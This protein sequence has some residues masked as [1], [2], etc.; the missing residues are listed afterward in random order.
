MS[1]VFVIKCD[2]CGEELPVKRFRRSILGSVNTIHIKG[3]ITVEGE[4][5]TTLDLIEDEELDFCNDQCLKSWLRDQ[6]DEKLGQGEL[7]SSD[8]DG[9]RVVG[10]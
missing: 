5:D 10:E 2:H 3:S 7:E 4:P 6:R 8:N 9:L 1:K